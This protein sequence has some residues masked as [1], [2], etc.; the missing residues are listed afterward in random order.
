M[1]QRV[2]P[3]FS[4]LRRRRLLPGREARLLPVF[5]ARFPPVPP[6]GRVHGQNWKLLSAAVRADENEMLRFGLR[7]LLPA[8][9]PGGIPPL[10]PP[11]F[12]AV[13]LSPPKKRSAGTAAQA[14]P[15][16][17]RGDWSAVCAVLA[18]FLYYMACPLLPASRKWA[19][20]QGNRPSPA[21]EI[22]PGSVRSVLS[23]YPD[24]SPSSFL[25]NGLLC[26]VLHDTTDHQILSILC[27]HLK[28]NLQKRRLI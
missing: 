27:Y 24:F 5:C 1:P 13:F 17:V 7:R 11:R 18:V 28:E 21:P 3:A 19:D 2:L 16:A 8:Q 15:P 9:L 22:P 4:F 20:F 26:N 23:H 25:P 14:C 10:Y 12:Q 6:A